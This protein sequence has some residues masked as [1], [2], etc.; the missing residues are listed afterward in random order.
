MSLAS[1]QQTLQTTFLWIFFSPAGISVSKHVQQLKKCCGHVSQQWHLFADLS[2]MSVMVTSPKLLTFHKFMI[3]FRSRVLK[4]I[5]GNKW[6]KQTNCCFS[7]PLPILQGNLTFQFMW[8]ALESISK[9]ESM[10]GNTTLSSTMVR[11]GGSLNV[12]AGKCFTL[13]CSRV[14]KPEVSF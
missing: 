7:A 8:E 12:S 4:N 2:T 3:H 13:E 5:T 14:W 11:K 1:S 10:C 6:Q 9:A